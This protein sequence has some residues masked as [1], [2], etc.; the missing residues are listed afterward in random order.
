MRR[1]CDLVIAERE[2]MTDLVRKLVP[3]LPASQ[4]NFLWLPLG[5]R[6]MPFAEACAAG[7]VL[8]RPFAGEGVRVT[9]GTHDENDRFAALLPALSSIKD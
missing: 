4:S 7:G 3:D 6:S 1:R 2:R 8:V 5:E 9:I